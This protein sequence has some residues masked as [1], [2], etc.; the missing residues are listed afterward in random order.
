MIIYIFFIFH[1]HIY[2]PVLLIS[3]EKGA[4]L[5]GRAPELSFQGWSRDREDAG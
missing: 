2:G 1:F 3:L 5:T 4:L